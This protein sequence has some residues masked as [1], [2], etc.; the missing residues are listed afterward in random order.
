MNQTKW[1]ALW[2]TTGKEMETIQE[3]NRKGAACQWI[4][5]VYVR[6]KKYRKAWHDEVKS[7]F[8]GYVF[9]TE[10]GLSSLHV[11]LANFSDF[12]CVLTA[13]KKPIP[14][15]PHEIEFIRQ[16]TNPEPNDAEPSI[17]V[18]KV[19]CSYGIIENDQ[20]IITQGPLRNREAMIKKIDRHKR[21]ATVELTML[22]RP[23]TVNLSLEIV[24]KKLAH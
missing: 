20:I 5:P 12:A 8:P 3:L 11:A 19:E 17:T 4:F 21:L 24:H 18:L 13:E 7:M 15:W 9:F 1:Y 6:K 16:I 10:S 22:G 2:V 14:L 23:M